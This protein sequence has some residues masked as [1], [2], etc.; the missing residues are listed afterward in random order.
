MIKFS[1]VLFLLF[2]RVI[3]CWYGVTLD[4]LSSCPDKTE[5]LEFSLQ[6]YIYVGFSIL[7][8]LLDKLVLEIDLAL[9]T[10]FNVF[11]VSVFLL[12][13]DLYNNLTLSGL[14]LLGVST[15]LLDAYG[16]S[17]LLTVSIVFIRSSGGF[18]HHIRF[19]SHDSI[20][21]FEDHVSSSDQCL[22]GFIQIPTFFLTFSLGLSDLFGNESLIF[23][24][25]ISVL[26]ILHKVNSRIKIR[27]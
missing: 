26:D 2:L 7:V 27:F 8:I 3:R 13:P 24:D 16:F 12:Y 18:L 5:R 15:V 19:C 25:M 23:E 1:E 4:K 10:V 11:Y 17:F 20:T 14:L 22:F 6:T 9:F 21:F